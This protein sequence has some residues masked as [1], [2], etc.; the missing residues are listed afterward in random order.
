MGFRE[1]KAS[2]IRCL[3]EGNFDHEYRKDMYEKNWLAAGRVTSKYVAEL[4]AGC[5][6][7]HHKCSPHHLD[8]SI[9]VH[10]FKARDAQTIWY[11]KAY[12]VE[13]DDGHVTYFISVHPPEDPPLSRTRPG[14]RR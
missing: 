14:G 12:L 13:D 5:T 10:V 2:V 1:T 9:L 6:G 3:K 4:L 11:I 7:T 8:K